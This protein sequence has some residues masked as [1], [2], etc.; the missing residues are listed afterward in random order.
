MESAEEATDDTLFHTEELLGSLNESNIHRAD[1]TH[2]TG[3]IFEGPKDVQPNPRGVNVDIHIE[4]KE[5]PQSYHISDN[6]LTPA[7]SRPA[8][9]R[10]VEQ[11]G[12]LRLDTPPPHQRVRRG[13]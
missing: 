4:P 7:N 9:Y 1:D 6:N 3:G 13:R 10:A 12:I 8:A 11:Q 5:H 2:K